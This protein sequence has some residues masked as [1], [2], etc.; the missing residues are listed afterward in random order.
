[1]GVMVRV[2]GLVILMSFGVWAGQQGTSQEKPKETPKGG[3]L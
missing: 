3:I 1:M 2:V